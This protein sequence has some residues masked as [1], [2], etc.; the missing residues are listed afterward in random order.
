MDTGA[1]NP[2]FS[3]Q[4]FKKILKAYNLEKCKPSTTPGNKKPPIAAEPLTRNKTQSTGQ[5]LDNYF[6]FCNYELTLRLRVKC[7]PTLSERQ[8]NEYTC[9]ELVD[10]HTC[11]SKNNP[12]LKQLND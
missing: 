9:D 7:L 5:Q 3:A 4:Y 2:S 10:Y 11:Q 1:M 6:G 12:S 8:S